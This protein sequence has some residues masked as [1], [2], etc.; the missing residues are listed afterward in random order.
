[1]SGSTTQAPHRWTVG[2]FEVHT[3][4]DGVI[5]SSFSLLQGIDTTESG[6]LIEAAGRVP[7]PRIAVNA[8][9]LRRGA[10]TV[11][12]DTGLGRRTPGFG[13]VAAG[14]RSLGVAPE[15]VTTIL[16]T[17]LHR[18]H[19]GGLLDDDGAR[20]FPRAGLVA[21]E[22]ETAYWLDGGMAA[23]VSEDKRDAFLVAQAA[24]R[25]YA[26]VIRR[27][28]GETEVLPGITAIPLA[29]HTHGHT[30]YLIASGGEQVLF[31]GDIVHFPD[32]QSARPEVT[33][34]FDVDPV[35]AVDTRRRV[36]GRASAERLRVA[37]HHMHWPGTGLV[38]QRED[39]AFRILP[40][41]I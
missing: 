10:E 39:G 16:M 33:I 31:W 5:E 29:G 7:L 22:L 6:V 27:I 11:L 32:I 38:E 14:L 23:R 36:F 34:G 9:L 17:H 8:F 15:A 2:E 40:D 28:D 4:L 1:M 20:A 12:I 25:P 41:P 3:L 30:G 19:V 24:L 21:S 18:D 13:G 26:D 35:T 37:G